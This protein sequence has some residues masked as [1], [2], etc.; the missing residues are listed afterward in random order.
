MLMFIMLIFIMLMFIMLMFIRLLFIMLMFIRLMFIRLL[1]IMLMFIMVWISLTNLTP[2][3]FCACP[4][5]GPGFL[6]TYVYCALCCVQWV[7]LRWEVIVHFLDIG[8]IHFLFIIVIFS[9]FL[10][11]KIICGGNWFFS[12]SILGW[13]ILVE[14][15]TFTV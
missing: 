14:L 15:L 1:F 9:I 8:R 6:T 7:Q 3:H 12:Y 10:V 11:T 5:P 13:S 4:K 2:P